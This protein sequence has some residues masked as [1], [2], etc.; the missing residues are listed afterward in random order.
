MDNPDIKI[1]SP[2]I[3]NVIPSL[4]QQTSG[5]PD[6]QWHGPQRHSYAEKKMANTLKR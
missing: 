2:R 6:Q 3:L 1:N 4:Q 5:N